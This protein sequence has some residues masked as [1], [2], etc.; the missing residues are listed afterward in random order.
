MRILVIA[1][2]E[3]SISPQQAIEQAKIAHG[4][5]ATVIA[6]PSSNNEYANLYFCAQTLLAEKIA[7]ILIDSKDKTYYNIAKE[8]LVSDAVTQFREVLDEV[9]SDIEEKM[10]K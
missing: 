6:L 4:S 1:P 8:R 5:F 9:I 10:N 2:E 3:E 7:N